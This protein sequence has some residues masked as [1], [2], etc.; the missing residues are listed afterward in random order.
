MTPTL[1]GH[2]SARALTIRNYYWLGLLSAI[3]F[4]NYLDRMVVAIL[5]EPMKLDL[6]LTDT[7]IGLISGSAFAFLY[8][9]ASLP[10]ARIADVWSR[11]RLISACL[12]FW[13]V[14]TALTGLSR[15]FVEVFLARMGVGLGEAGCVPPAHSFIGDLFP[16]EKRA[17]AI[18]I[19]QSG[20]QIGLTLGLVLAAWMGQ[21]WGWRTTLVICGLAG[22]PLALLTW[23]TMRD[24]YRGKTQREARGSVSF[25]NVIKG[26][27]QNRRYVQLTLGL[28][29]GS[30][31]TFGIAQWIAAFYIRIHDLTLLEVGAYSAMAGGFGGILGAVVGGLTLNALRAK[32][33]RWECWFP[34]A[35]FALALPVFVA[36]FLVPNY[37]HAFLLQFVGAILL[38]GGTTA[39]LSAL[40]TGIATDRRATA[41]A[42]TLLLTTLFGLGLGPALIGLVS[43]M[44]AP[45]VGEVSISYA[46]AAACG[47]LAWTCLHFML[48]SRAP[49][50]VVEEPDK[51]AEVG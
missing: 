49:T 18:G 33:T 13:S 37:V 16:P 27:I 36:C 25:A 15:N 20:G 39:V 24:E 2:Q 21:V 5:V 8:A 30:L 31:T 46:L 11:T 19:F 45:S 22:L 12:A 29:I 34:A 7:E 32:D 47:L 35:T 28:T 1:P 50:P 44:L 38:S 43:D 40:Q 48:A 51:L 41:I 4:F 9:I 14:M 26:L 17:L 3:S 6:G 42:L 23:T 10:L